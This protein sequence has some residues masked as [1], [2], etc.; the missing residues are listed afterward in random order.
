M[1]FYSGLAKGYNSLYKEEQLKK[2]RVIKQNMKIIP[3]L[4]DIGCGTG[5]STSFFK[6]KSIGIDNNKEM[7]KQAGKNCIYADAESL[8]FKD[9]SFSTIISD[10]TSSNDNPEASA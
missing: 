5:I 8:P 6:V 3:P 7:L 9:K 4:L 2:L 1:D 10:P